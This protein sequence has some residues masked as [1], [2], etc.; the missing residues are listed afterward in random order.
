MSLTGLFATFRFPMPGQWWYLNSSRE[1]SFMTGFGRNFGIQFAGL[2][3]VVLAAAA[4]RLVPHPSN[5]SPITAMALFAGA[6][7]SGFFAGAWGGRLSKVFALLFPLAA[8]FLS[9]LILGFHDQMIPVYFAFAVVTLFGL[10]LQSRVTAVR[11]GLASVAGALIFF[12]ITNFAIWA[13]SGMYEHT[14]AGFV[15]CF[16]LALPFLQKSLVGDLFF[17]AVL[18]GAWAFLVRL[19]PKLRTA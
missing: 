14:G 17:S 3:F 2:A 8:L 4:L 16:T 18:F 12:V 7:F 5:F 9:D 6:Y 15:K 10:T 1:A 13:K 19:A 11:V